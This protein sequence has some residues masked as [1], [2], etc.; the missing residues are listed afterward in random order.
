MVR[1]DDS[2]A[3]T[4]RLIRQFGRVLLVI[5]GADDGR[6]GQARHVAD[7]LIEGVRHQS[8]LSKHMPQV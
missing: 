1:E 4:R 7:Q 8:S 6:R 3:T 2:T 5:D